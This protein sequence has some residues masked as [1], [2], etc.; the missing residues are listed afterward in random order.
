ME[1]VNVWTSLAMECV[2]DNYWT[3]TGRWKQ[4]YINGNELIVTGVMSI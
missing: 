1:V 4:K 3:I 2:V